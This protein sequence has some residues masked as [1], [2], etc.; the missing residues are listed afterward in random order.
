MT[1]VS[2]R[3]LRAADRDA[4]LAMVR[5]S[6]ELHRPWA[7]PPERSDQFDELLSRCSRED[8]ACFVV[9]DDESGDIAGVFNISQIVRGSFQSAFLGYY[10]S[11]RHA[12]KGLMRDGL[13][14][15]LD[16]AF[17]PLSLHRIEANIQPG[18]AAS[19]ALARGAGFRLEGYSPRYLLIGGQWRDHERY[20]LTV[21]ERARGG[22][23]RAPSRSGGRAGWT[24]SSARQVVRVELDVRRPRGSPR[25]GRPTSC[26]G[27]AGC[28]RSGASSHASATCDGVAPCFSATPAIAGSAASF[29][30]AAGERRAEREERHEG[31]LV[32]AAELD[33]RLVVA[34]ERCCRRSAPRRA[35]R[36]RAPARRPRSVTLETP[37]RSSLPSW[38]MSSSTPSCSGSGTSAPPSVAEQPQV[39]EVHALDAQRAQV[40][41]DAR[42]QLVG[43]SAGSQPPLSSRRAPTLVTSFRLSG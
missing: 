25:G 41:L 12:G 30:R 21:D 19:I 23:D 14:R 28:G 26:R 4:F 39:D 42:A 34:V 31:D 20:A 36:A 29:C 27:S 24:A 1:R 43:A 13:Q 10:G 11:A 33:D 18:N 9:I 16:Y 32:L 35:R 3:L 5:E 40:V 17:G 22:A 2:I 6:R 37:M 8:F 38:R 15:V 7:Y